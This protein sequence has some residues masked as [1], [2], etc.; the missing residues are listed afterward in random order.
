M[1]LL[2]GLGSDYNAVVTAINIRD[3]KISIEAVHSMLLAF[4]HRLEQQSSIDLVPIFACYASFSNNRAED[5]AIPQIPATTP[6]E[7]GHTAHVCYHR[8][9]ISFQTSQN[10]GTP[11]LNTGN[12]N[13]IPVMVATSYNSAGDDWYLDSGASHHFTQNEGNLNN[14][15]PYTG[16]DRVTVSNGKHLSISNT[17]SHWLV[18]NSHSFQL[19]KVFH[20]PFILA[21][22]ISVAKF[23]SDNNALIEFW[24]NSFIVKD[25]HTKKVLVQ[26]NLENGLYKFLVLH[27]NKKLAYVRVHNTST[28]HSHRLSPVHN[29]VELWHHHGH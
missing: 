15:T 22:L 25:L 4:E 2:G 17:S 27:K 13:T 12:H 24:S 5:K 9:D 1:N 19:R 3:D 6:T 11:S 28:F 10:N 23:Y 8:F 7:F 29:K 26:G 20:V 21:N 14:S 18:S 16:T